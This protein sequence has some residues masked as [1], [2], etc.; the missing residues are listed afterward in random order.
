MTTIHY[1]DTPTEG[2]AVVTLTP[3]SLLKKYLK[4]LIHILGPGKLERAFRALIC[5][6]VTSHLCR[7]LRAE[8]VHDLWQAVLRIFRW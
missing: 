7:P 6:T 1:S 2:D 3:G 4:I 8:L 5:A